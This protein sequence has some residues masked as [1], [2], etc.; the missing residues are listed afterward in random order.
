[1]PACISPRCSVSLVSTVRTDRPL[2]EIGLGTCKRYGL[3]RK[4]PSNSD[5]PE[6]LWMECR[7]AWR[8]LVF[9]S[10]LASTT[11]FS[12]VFRLTYRQLAISFA[13]LCAWELRTVT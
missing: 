7:K 4:H 13:G 9:F 8:T 11:T 6:S 2:P 12:S 1:M 10:R 3:E 5:L